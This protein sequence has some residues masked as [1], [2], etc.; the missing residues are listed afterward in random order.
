MDDRDGRRGLPVTAPDAHR[1]AA[2]LRE[3]GVDAPDVAV[4]LGSG[5]GSFADELDDARSFDA[6]DLDGFPRSRVPGHAGRLVAGSIGGRRV[7]VQQ[8]RIHLYE[9]WTAADVTTVVRAFAEFG[10]PALLLTNAAGG[11]V[12]EWPPGSL[13]RIID[14]VNLQSATPL[15]PEGARRGGGGP[16]DAELGD[17]L[18]AAARDANVELF[19]G[20]YVANEGPAYETPAEVRM[21]GRLGG[22]AVG[23]STAMEA[24]AGFAAGMRVAAV[25]CITNHAAGI[26][27]TPLHH[28][29]V[30]EVGKRASAAFVRLLG[31][32]VPRLAT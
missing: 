5:L 31:T 8:G 13:M 30:V 6:D 11:L 32:A 23:M 1:L 4:V 7:L 17:R 2:A 28:D 29:E 26:S 19:T 18:D 14:H 27:E 9:G 21:A 12:P 20:V 16:Y 22:H 15:G 3:R 10:T 24:L 25:S